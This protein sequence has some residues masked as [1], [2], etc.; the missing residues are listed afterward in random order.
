MDDETNDVT[1]YAQMI[2]EM[3]D[4]EAEKTGMMNAGWRQTEG[5]AFYYQDDDDPK[6]TLLIR[7]FRPH[8]DRDVR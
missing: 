5:G 8:P 6:T 4:K 7:T 3:L 1:K 2:E